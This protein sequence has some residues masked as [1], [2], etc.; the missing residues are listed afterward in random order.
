MKFITEED[1]RDLYRKEPFTTYEMEPGARLTPGARQFLTD[2]GINMFDNGPFTKGNT[3]NVKQP[4]VPPE[5]R[6]KLKKKKL[7]C[8]IKTVEALFL[9]TGEELLSGDAHLAQSVISLGKQFSGIKNA[10]DGKGSVEN[11]CCTECTGINAD[12]FSDDLGDCFEITES[13]MEMKKGRDIII[14]HRLR[15]ALREIEPALLEAYEGTEDENGL[16]KEAIKKINQ[17]VNTLSQKI[18]SVSGGKTCQRKS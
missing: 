5:S 2:R 18:C 1:L 7:H 12:N 8:S 13:H 3:V 6:N 16:C 9:L 17:I 14:L 10:L 15:C 11:L 4:A